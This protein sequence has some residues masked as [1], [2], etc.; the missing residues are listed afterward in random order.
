MPPPAPFP[1]GAAGTILLNLLSKTG[2]RSRALLK[3]LL[4]S[5]IG[6]AA[7][8]LAGAVALAF[9]GEFHAMVTAF[10]LGVLLGLG[11]SVGAAILWVI[12]SAGR[13]SQAL[14]R[15]AATFFLFAPFLLITP[16][17]AFA[18]DAWRLRRFVDRELAPRL[19]TARASLESYPPRLAALQGKFPS[20][21]W[22]FRRC[23]YERDAKGYSLSVMDPGACGHTLTYRS[24]TRSWSEAFEVCWY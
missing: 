10:E 20:A 7:G 12:P 24:T 19:E 15:L 9:H 13:A 14:F 8:L 16:R 6:L 2:M 21:P 4:L 22:L 18:F 5:R 11:L 3:L 17:V 1:P 23:S